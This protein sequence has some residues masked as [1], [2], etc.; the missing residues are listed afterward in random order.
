M[1]QDEAPQWYW[2][3][4]LHFKPGDSSERGIQPAD[5][6]VKSVER[7]IE[8]YG[9]YISG[10]NN[11]SEDANRRMF[12]RWKQWGADRL[13]RARGENMI[14]SGQ[15]RDASG[16]YTQKQLGY[17][18]FRRMG[19]QTKNKAVI[20]NKKRMIIPFYSD[21][22]S[23][24]LMAITDDCGKSWKFSEPLVAAGNIHPSIVE[25]LT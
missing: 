3:D 15:L 13:A 23:F 16:G 19:W 7:Q 17:P 20:V 25:E 5:R 2:Q 21:G 11:L 12:Q 1:E 6:F 9:K 10:S 8:E 4:V 24:S 14:K 18:Y 22:F